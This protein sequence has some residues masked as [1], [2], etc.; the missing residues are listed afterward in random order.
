MVVL[1]EDAIRHREEL[2]LLVA[3]SLDCALLFSVEHMVL[4]CETERSE[5]SVKTRQKER[6]K[7]HHHPHTQK[8]PTTKNNQ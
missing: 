6:K 8:K 2:T 1:T 4:N 7:H 3:N 5:G